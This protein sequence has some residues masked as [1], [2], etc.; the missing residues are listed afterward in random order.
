MTKKEQIIEDI[1]NNMKKCEIA[2]KYDVDPS[3][4][5][6]VIKEMEIEK[7]LKEYKIIREMIKRKALKAYR[8]K[9][10]KEEIELWEIL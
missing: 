1:E 2:R 7:Q 10:T 3:Y 5:S 9:M 8:N 4:V 6:H